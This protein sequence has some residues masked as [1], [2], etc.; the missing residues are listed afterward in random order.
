MRL[1]FFAC[2]ILVSNFVYAQCLIDI[3]TTT[4]P[5]LDIDICDFQ[6]KQFTNSAGITFY[7]ING[8]Y[9]GDIHNLGQADYEA[10]IATYN[11]CCSGTEV[12]PIDVN[13]NSGVEITN[14]DEIDFTAITE[15]LQNVTVNGEVTA[16]VDLQSLIDAIDNINFDGANVNV[17]LSSVT[18]ALAD[19]LGQLQNVLTVT[20]SVTVDQSGTI[21]TLNEIL[22]ALNGLQIDINSSCETPIFTEICNETLNVNV[23]NTVSVIGTVTSVIDGP[24]EVT[25][26]PNVNINSSCENPVSVKDCDTQNVIDA[27]NAIDLV[28]FTDVIDA[29]NNLVITGDVNANIDFADVIDAINSINISGQAVNANVDFSGVLN[30]LADLQ[31][32]IE[33]NNEVVVSG[34]VDAAIT[35]LPPV[36]INTSC[37]A[38]LNVKD[39]DNQTIIKLLTIQ[40]QNQ[41]KII[42]LLTDQLACCKE[43]GTAQ[44]DLKFEKQT[45][46]TNWAEARITDGA[47]AQFEY[48]PKNAT[49]INVTGGSGVNGAG[50]IYKLTF[51]AHPQGAN[52]VPQIQVYNDSNADTGIPEIISQTATSVT[53]QIPEGD[54]G[55]SVDDNQYYPHNIIIPSNPVDVVTDVKAVQ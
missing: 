37:E 14:L 31:A 30:S 53:Y 7:S 29:L 18:D 32:A 24:I 5:C 33:A 1:L 23:G 26:L 36:Q 13:I 25:S 15:A 49:N 43:S 38:P 50:R 52:Y 20:G 2:L 19:I 51:P 34:E 48:P 55:G 6:F 42:Q 11:S 41:D 16:I 22:N 45:I 9:N 46:C 3:E 21:N 35:S 47:N 8:K 17:D 12:G 28:D 54:E 44:I 4:G 27:I 40:A 39:C 10:A